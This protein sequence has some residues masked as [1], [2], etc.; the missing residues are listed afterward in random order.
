MRKSRARTSKSKSREPSVSQDVVNFVSK[1]FNN[2]VPVSFLTGLTKTYCK[3]PLDANTPLVKR[4]SEGKFVNGQKLTQYLGEKTHH[5]K[6]K[7]LSDE[8][9]K[10]VFQNICNPEGKLSFEYIMKAADASGIS[11]PAKLAK[12][13]VRKYGKR[14]DHLNV[15]DCSRVIKR[16]EERKNVKSA[17]Q[18]QR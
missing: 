9:I 12:A 16:R 15:E 6:G 1:K 7:P 8:A 11:F 5:E 13:A 10:R 17:P 14:K 4:N 18:K 2:K 3:K